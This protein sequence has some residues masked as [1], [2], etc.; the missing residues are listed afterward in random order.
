[1]I[2]W[3]PPV[4]PRTD[5]FDW[6][7][8]YLDDREL[9]T[10][11]RV[12]T[13]LFTASLAAIPLVLLTSD[14]GPDHSIPVAAS[15]I[16]AVLGTLGAVLWLAR[17]PTRRQST[18]FCLAATG[19]I[20]LTCLAQSDP[21]TGLMGC[22]TFAVIGGFIAFFHTLKLVVV[23]LVAAA[24]CAGVLTYR[25]IAE[26]GN[27]ALAGSGLLIVAALNVGTPFGIYSLAHALRSDLRDAGHDPLTGLLNRR[28]FHHAAYELLMRNEEPEGQVVVMMID[29]DNFKHLNDTQGHS[30]GDD[31]LVNVGA[32]L[33]DTCRRSA[34]IGR[35]GGE[36]FVVLDLVR[37]G[38]VRDSADHTST[39]EDLRAAI[40]TNPWQI[41]A[42]I[43]MAVAQLKTS[44]TRD[45]AELIEHLVHQADLAMYAAKR[46]GG[47]R[48]RRSEADPIHG[49]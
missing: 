23:N 48:V 42:S 39:A 49:R 46:A 12:T 13:S 26:T 27:L 41:T 20:T 8:A 29:L 17:W 28:S 5:Q 1:M 9:Q 11:W 14:T 36:E 47:N 35:A 30:A 34:V 21:Y 2:R 6:F 37:S 24:G 22:T 18:L 40:A 32:A 7:S 4:V 43:G 38:D 31:A 16:S 3:S 15:V 10:Q 25:L 19:S 33:R 44:S 45:S